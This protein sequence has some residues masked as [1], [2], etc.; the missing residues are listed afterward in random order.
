VTR[1]EDSHDPQLCSRQAI[2]QKAAAE[3]P[4]DSNA[5][6]EINRNAAGYCAAAV[7]T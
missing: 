6:A 1:A 7:L 2:E 4:T 3:L 5:T